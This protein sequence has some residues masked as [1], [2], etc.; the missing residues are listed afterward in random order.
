MLKLAFNKDVRT[1]MSM[2]I[3][4]GSQIILDVENPDSSSIS[5]L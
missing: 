3:P 2:Q 5:G 4:D 1:L